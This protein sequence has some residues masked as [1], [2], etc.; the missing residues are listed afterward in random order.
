MVTNA[1]KGGENIMNYTVQSLLQYILK[2]E[3]YLHSQSK[4]IDHL[5][6][7]FLYLEEQ[8]EEI[9][10]KP[11]TNIEKVE[12]KFDQLKIETLEGVLNIGLNPADQEAIEQFSV[13]NEELNVDDVHRELKQQIFEQCVE[14]IHSYLQEECPKKI[15][16]FAK[17]YEYELDETY[18]AI[19]IEDIRKQLEGRITYY[20]QRLRLHEQTDIK[21]KI[22]W[23]E[24]K[25]KKD[26]D[27]SIDHFFKHFP[28][29]K[30][31][32]ELS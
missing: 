23:I 3:Q 26:I 20:L 19:I 4:R 9:K 5:E 17:N 15:E 1:D 16:D 24:E 32:D 25:V 10:N 14:S 22:Q 28:N 11:Y 13:K 8:L 30:K 12:Y 31:G 6:K 29:K 27:Q 18:K 21:E 7:G 2:L